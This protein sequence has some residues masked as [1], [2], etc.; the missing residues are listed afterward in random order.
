MINLTDLEIRVYG[1]VEKGKLFS[2]IAEEQDLSTEMVANIYNK[3]RRKL[4]GDPKRSRIAK[5]VLEKQGN[6]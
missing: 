5:H 4:Y 3:V 1:E 6:K 2:M